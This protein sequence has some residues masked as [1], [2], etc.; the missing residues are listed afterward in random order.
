MATRHLSTR[1]RL[2]DVA[3]RMYAEH[4]LEAVPTRD[5]AVEAGQRNG[6]AV[7]YHF[8]GREGLISAILKRRMDQI[9]AV[10]RD[11]LQQLADQGKGSDVRA[12]VEA[13][14]MPFAEFVMST[15][16]TSHYARFIEQAL[17]GLSH[18][19]EGAGSLAEFSGA[20]RDVAD[21]LARALTHLDPKVARRRIR[22]ANS[23]VVTEVAAIE[24][25]ADP[26]SYHE[27]IIDLVEMVTAALTATTRP[28]S[29]SS[30]G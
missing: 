23:I 13:S 10:R 12:L 11:R 21:Q 24:R 25:S 8:G 18:G 4:G 2:M 14:V 20:A 28:P 1:E 22:L 9:N 19:P 26:E 15:R 7:N 5:I 30:P 16:P 29:E 27:R 6:S 3:E 17:V